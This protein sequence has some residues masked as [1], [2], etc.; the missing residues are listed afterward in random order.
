MI[1]TALYLCGA[2]RNL[3]ISAPNII[4]YIIEP[5]NCDVF[6]HAWNIKNTSYGIHRKQP[7][8]NI[9]INVDKIVDLYKPKLIQL[10]AQSKCTIDY[11]FIVPPTLPLSIDNFQ[12]MCYSLQQCNRLRQ[13]SQ[14]KY[15]Y[16]I[17]GR[18]DLIVSKYIN[19][20]D[21]DTAMF[22]GLKQYDHDPKYI[23]DNFFITSSPNMDYACNLYDNIRRLYNNGV[24]YNPE[25]MLTSYIMETLPITINN[26][27]V[28]VRKT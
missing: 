10:D 15:D 23:S 4:K 27:G 18:F 24:L 16:C 2:I 13:S 19:V 5:N 1:K 7:D 9:D 20:T 17:R 22:N 6:I 25:M 11:D 3:E 14:I 12:Y 8:T 21:Y 28:S 26:F